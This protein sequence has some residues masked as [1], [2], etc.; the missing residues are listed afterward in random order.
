MTII[1][2]RAATNN[3]CITDLNNNAIYQEGNK[4]YKFVFT[5]DVQGN[6]Q[7]IFLAPVIRGNRY[8]FTLIEPTDLDFPKLGFYTYRIYEV[9]DIT[10]NENLLQTGKMKLIELRT[11]LPAPTINTEFVAYGN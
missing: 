9:E 3:F 5:N 8:N 11:D 7:S 4:T 10:L 2:T 1:I 6:S